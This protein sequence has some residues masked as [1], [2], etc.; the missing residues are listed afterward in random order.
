[1]AVLA[2]WRDKFKWDWGGGMEDPRP[3][4]MIYLMWCCGLRH[5]KDWASCRGFSRWLVVV[6]FR[7]SFFFV[8][9]VLSNKVANFGVLML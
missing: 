1:M 5:T 9:F 2:V 8:L 7:C 6:L 4:C 3:N